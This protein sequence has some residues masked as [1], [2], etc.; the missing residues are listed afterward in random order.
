MSTLHVGL[1]VLQILS[2][3]ILTICGI[4]FAYLTIQL[5]HRSYLPMLLIVIFSFLYVLSGTLA[6]TGALSVEGNFFYLLQQLTAA[7]G[8]VLLLL[9]VRDSLPAHSKQY[10]L[11][12]QI[13]HI[14]LVVDIC[15]AVFIVISK[16]YFG[17]SSILFLK[18]ARNFLT[19][20]G[21]TYSFVI[22]LLETTKRRRVLYYA[23]IETGLLLLIF[24]T[25]LVYIYHFIPGIVS[26]TVQ[27]SAI[28]GGQMLFTLL[29]AAA[30]IQQF[31]VNSKEL[32]LTKDRLA[33]LAYHDGLTG[34][35]N[36]QALSDRLQQAIA[37]A[38][39][40]HSDHILGLLMIDLDHFKR[41]NDGISHDV[42]DQILTAF[43]NRIQNRVRSSDFFFR[44]GGDEFAIVLTQLKQPTDA[45]VVSEKILES[46]R[47]PFI[48]HGERLHLSCTIGISIFPKDAE[49]GDQ[50]MIRADSALSE[51]K[52]DRNVYRFY[53]K[54]MQ[55]DA[56]RKMRLLV[57]LREA[58]SNNEFSLAFQPQIAAS[59]KIIG[60]EAL[61]R[62]NNADLGAISPAE[63]I[64][65][66]EESGAIMD[67]GNWVIEKACAAANYW[68]KIQLP[69]FPV[70]VNL[71][72]RQLRNEKLVSHI[73]SCLNYYSLKPE[74]LHV[75]I[76]ESSVL[77]NPEAAI[78]VLHRLNNL[79]V[80]IA[81]DDFGTGFSSLSYL[82][83]L[84]V[85]C[86][87]IDR[88]F[89]LE[90]PQDSKSSSLL[91]GII[92]M[93]EGLGL[94]IIAE[95]VE[96]ASQIDFLNNNAPIVVQG[97][98][99]SRPLFQD[100]FIEFVRKLDQQSNSLPEQK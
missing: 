90:L 85:D 55:E 75:E 100:E 65:I 94:S 18:I 80:R 33:F 53:T 95:G 41:I 57:K 67:I 64:P 29:S 70:A 21:S 10:I 30:M 12:N 44:I 68:Q 79:G 58:L 26:N 3:G 6:H 31:V 51:G 48:V 83:E 98:F 43:A 49:S 13:F 37:Q 5:T 19:L 25:I 35:M 14:T 59:G 92:S 24:S 62:W 99:Y 16:L 40:S 73:S 50:L 20:A 72:A 27:S 86:V 1:F 22:L 89:F 60:A 36:R 11:T 97:F 54:Q 9:F 32:N 7:V 81:I 91:L 47:D 39:R 71:S 69:P 78:A 66:A 17:S 8:P 4:F 45:A 87:K 23:L 61:I 96:S 38:K 77:D 82:K 2:L 42:G 52:R 76:T 28:L 15:I 74:Q 46:M 56:A 63:F 88:S 34:L 93:V 84:P